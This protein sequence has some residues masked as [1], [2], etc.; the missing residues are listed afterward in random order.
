[1]LGLKEL[2]AE[3]EDDEEI[4]YDL[5][6]QATQKT[7]MSQGST[8]YKLHRHSSLNMSDWIQQPHDSAFLGKTFQEKG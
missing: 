3:A 1:M 7:E 4:V 5:I 2:A 6:P 8:K